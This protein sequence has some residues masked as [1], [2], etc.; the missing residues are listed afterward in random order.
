VIFLSK[1][2][3]KTVDNVLLIQGAGQ[4][5]VPAIKIQDFPSEGRVSRIKGITTSRQHELL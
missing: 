5:Y 1:R 4:N 2:K 3:R